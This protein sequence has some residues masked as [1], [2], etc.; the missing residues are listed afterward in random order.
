MASDES[1]RLHPA[2]PDSPTAEDV[3]NHLL[4]VTGRAIMTGDE[5]LF[6]DCFLLPQDIE[7]YE[8]RR[9][10]ET[11]EVLAATFRRVT[12]HFQLSGVTDLVRH[13]TQARYAAPDQVEAIHVARLMS[14]VR[15]LR[16]PYYC[17]SILQLTPAGWKIAHS[18]Y[19]IPDA[20]AHMRALLGPDP[21]PQAPGPGVGP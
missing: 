2:L 11:V 19:A 20:P 15:L 1:P 21:D 10:I 3:S 17:L 14:G 5:R 9:R 7:T 6:V 18:Q 8:G 12:Q 16:A 13:C 4:A